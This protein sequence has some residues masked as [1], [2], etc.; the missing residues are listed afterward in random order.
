M[1]LATL[2]PVEAL[3]GCQLTVIGAGIAAIWRGNGKTLH[4]VATLAWPVPRQEYCHVGVM[5][6]STLRMIA[7]RLNVA[8]A[9]FVEPGDKTLRFASWPPISGLGYP[10]R[11]DAT[12]GA[13]VCLPKKEF[14]P[15]EQPKGKTA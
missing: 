6:W 9:V 14:K 11:P 7:D 10:I 15:V 8:S 3:W 5:A 13:V 2:Q 12:A 1:T 4:S